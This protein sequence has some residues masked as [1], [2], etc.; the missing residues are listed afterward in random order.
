[1]IT[2]YMDRAIYKQKQFTQRSIEMYNI[3]ARTYKELESSDVEG[4]W[5][6]KR[7]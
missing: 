2:E 5:Q 3:R 1:M 4:P 6:H 7:A